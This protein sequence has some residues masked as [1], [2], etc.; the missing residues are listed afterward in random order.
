MKECHVNTERYMSQHDILT[1]VA[2]S[3]RVAHNLSVIF[4]NDAVHIHPP[5]TYNEAIVTSRASV[6]PTFVADEL[7]SY[8]QA[9]RWKQEQ[10]QEEDTAPGN[11]N[12]R[13]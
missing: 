4:A 7:P 10:Q 8:E 12:D 13:H 1:A 6:N 3:S 2:N 11:Q 9:E 5:P